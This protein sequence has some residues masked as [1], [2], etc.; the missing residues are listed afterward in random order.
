MHKLL[1]ERQSLALGIGNGFQALI[2]LGL[3]PNGKI[4]GQDINAPTLTY[5]TINRHAQRWQVKSSFQTSHLG[6]RKLNSVVYI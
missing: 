5:N 2:K 6:Y 4:T 3:V 1:N